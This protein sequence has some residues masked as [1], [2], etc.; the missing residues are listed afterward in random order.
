MTIL[1]KAT[2]LNDRDTLNGTYIELQTRIQELEIQHKVLKELDTTNITLDDALAL[3]NQYQDTVNQ[4]NQLRLTTQT[5]IDANNTALTDLRDKI[6]FVITQA[7]ATKAAADAEAAAAAAKTAAEEAAALQKAKNSLQAYIASLR[8][9]LQGIN[10]NNLIH[11]SAQIQNSADTIHQ[12]DTQ[13]YTAVS[14]ADEAISQATRDLIAAFKKD[15]GEEVTT[16]TREFNAL[17]QEF[18]R[19]KNAN[20]T[21]LVARIKSLEGVAGGANVTAAKAITDA[22]STDTQKPID[23]K[24]L[25]EIKG[26]AAELAAEF[27]TKVATEFATR[28]VEI[29]GKIEKDKAL[30]QEKQKIIEEYRGIMDILDSKEVKE[31]E[32]AI[33]ENIKNA[34]A[35]AE[36]AVNDNGNLLAKS[37]ANTKFG[38]AITGLN[39]S[40]LSLQTELQNKKLN[41]DTKLKELQTKSADIQLS[42]PIDVAP[43]QARI[44]AL[45][46]T[47]DEYE[48]LVKFQKARAAELFAEKEAAR[49]RSGSPEMAESQP[50]PQQQPKPPS[51]P[52]PIHSRPPIKHSS[53]TTSTNALAQSSVPEE[54]KRKPGSRYSI[55]IPTPTD[56]KE[57]SAPPNI[58]KVIVYEEDDRGTSDDVAEIINVNEFTPEIEALFLSFQ[59]ANKVLTPDFLT[60]IKDNAANI[61]IN[62]RDSISA[63]MK[64]IGNRVI[65]HTD[66][67][68]FVDNLGKRIAETPSI[69]KLM[70]LLDTRNVRK[71]QNS[72]TYQNMYLTLWRFMDYAKGCN[73]VLKEIF[74]AKEIKDKRLNPPTD[75]IRKEI[76]WIQQLKNTLFEILFMDFSKCF[77]DKGNDDGT[78]SRFLF[79]QVED[80]ET[81]QYRYRYRYMLNWV[82][83]IAFHCYYRRTDEQTKTDELIRCGELIEHLYH[84]FLGWMEKIKNDTLISIFYPQT[85]DSATYISMVKKYITEEITTDTTLQPLRTNIR[86][87]LCSFNRDGNRRNEGTNN[88]SYKDALL[89]SPRSVWN[90]V[91]QPVSPPVSPPVSQPVS[92]RVSPR[93]TTPLFTKVNQNGK[94]V[95]PSNERPPLRRRVSE[96]DIRKEPQASTKKIQ[97]PRSAE[98]GGRTRK[99]RKHRTP[100]SSTPAPATRRHRDQSSSSH[101]R[102]RRYANTRT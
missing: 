41:L 13:L 60:K 53:L 78:Y 54:K 18:G 23:D 30:F 1:N 15:T 47:N 66:T 79:Q 52:R 26:S 22:L 19:A 31:K 34:Q 96:S 73:T 40:I 29:E 91:S 8:S 17:N 12:Y 69:E 28:K 85:K 75:K 39:A 64:E 36:A 72:K 89:A 59:E 57:S 27:G 6:K 58:L 50:Q 81:Q 88:P 74:T 45:K 21:D 77:N 32:A 38:T 10:E 51:E 5:K 24:T 61:V 56:T 67:A 76:G 14:S 20:V 35:A 83:L 55:F 44:D 7:E 63:E 80:K 87:V 33:Q 95:V 11:I 90:P 48:R 4:F 49:S 43:I 42:P 97:I 65:Q 100:T 62:D 84:T 94:S 101:K 99:T 9:Q 102:T 70:K 68:R 71:T 37:L 92:P 86:T 98:V 46:E 93:E 2:H 3:L 25:G 82:I 16:K